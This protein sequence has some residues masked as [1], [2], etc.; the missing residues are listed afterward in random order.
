MWIFFAVIPSSGIP[1]DGSCFAIPS[2]LDVCTRLA[3]GTLS[4]WRYLEA[5]FLSLDSS[6]L[7][8]IP[9]LPSVEN[10]REILKGF[11]VFLFIACDQQESLYNILH[12]IYYSDHINITIII[13][14]CVFIYIWINTLFYTISL[15]YLHLDIF[16]Q[17]WS[18]CQPSRSPRSIAARC[19][20]ARVRWSLD[21]N[22]GIWG[23]TMDLYRWINVAKHPGGLFIEPAFSTLQC[24]SLISFHKSQWFC[25]SLKVQFP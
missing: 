18:N 5:S 16:T 6:N 19:D 1:T 25:I 8:E 15:P 14:Y 13:L 2:W 3:W 24:S 4:P 20:V 10:S 9:D 23:V 7:T 11:Y 21:E 17:T 12:A 22:A